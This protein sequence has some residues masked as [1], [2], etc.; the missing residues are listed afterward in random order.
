MGLKRKSE[1]HELAAKEP[2][3]PIFIVTVIVLLAAIATY[4]VPAGQFDR[5]PNEVTGYDMVD[6]D[7]FHFVEK[8]P[9]PIFSLFTSLT[10][11]LQEAS[12]VIFFLM[13]IGGTFKVVDATGALSVGLSNAVIRMKGKELLLIPVSVFLFSTISAFAACS[14]EYLAFM[15]LM[16]VVCVAAGFDSVTAIAL[17]FCSS[18]VGYAGGMTQA[19]T[20]G[21]AQ[22]IAELP[23]FSGMGLRVALFLVLATITSAFL[24]I[25]AYR[26]K[27]NPELNEMRETDL[28]Y[29][30]HL[31]LEKVPPISGRQKLILAI[32][33]GSFVVVA[34][35][36]MK[37]EFFIDEMSGIFLITGLLVAVVARMKPSQFIDTFVEGCKDLLFAGLIIGMCNSVTLILTQAGILDT[38]IYAAGSLL[39]GLD[40]RIS[41]CGM[42]VFQDLLNFLIPSGSGQ[43]AITM[44]FMAPLSDFLGVSRQ[45]AVLA[46]QT[47]D[48]FTNAITPTAG[49][50]MAALAICHVPYKKWFKDIAPLWLLWA[51]VACTFLVIAVSIGYV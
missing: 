23:L 40:A 6:V 50:L 19:F 51:L 24:M 9:L 48:A 42:F 31:D 41:A 18:A 29:A 13:I 10:L 46:F 30:E 21:V 28:R 15:P 2:I 5:I 8:K 20:V 33:A 49:D 1:K 47:G 32:F 37:F 34:F 14:E 12:Y 4:I 27:K 22:T 26:L 3:N 25:R 16:Y 44:P 36:V 45:T 38:L 35:T 11:G 17:L 43:A 7:S 39:R